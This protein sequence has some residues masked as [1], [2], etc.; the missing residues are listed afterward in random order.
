MKMK[1]AQGI[2]PGA[3]DGDWRTEFRDRIE[4][5]EKNSV[6][7]VSLISSN[8]GIDKDGFQKESAAGDTISFIADRFDDLYTSEAGLVE[9]IILEKKLGMIESESTVLIAA[10]KEKQYLVIHKGGGLI[11]NESDGK[12]FVLSRQQGDALER[13][14]LRV[15]K[16]EL[17]DSF[18]F[19]LLGDGAC[20][21][22]FDY[23]TGNLS[24]ACGTFF[25]W[26][27]EFD[28]EMVSG[29]LVDNINKYFLKDTNGHD[30][31]IGIMVTDESSAE[32][33]GRPQQSEPAGKPA[34]NREPR[35]YPVVIVLVLAVILVIFAATRQPDVMAPTNTDILNSEYKTPAAS[36]KIH[37]PAVSFST[38]TPASYDAGE[39][40]VGTDIPAGEYFFWT[41]KMLEP[42]RIKVNGDT[43]LSG[44]LYCMTIRLNDWDTLVSDYR[45]TAAENVNSVQ[46]VDGVF[47]SGKYKIGKDIVPGIY[48]VKP[49]SQNIEGRYYSISDEE[50]SNDTEFS[51]ETTVEVP[52]EGYVVFLSFGFNRRSE[53][54]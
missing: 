2:V 45:F 7:A 5:I 46:P 49:T 24:P 44:E 50:I 12:C 16:G 41:G 29:A 9:K 3:S 35:K 34:M 36:D 30:I 47:I 17:G 14:N 18:G 38:D 37:E 31:S 43:C 48:T 27:K 4:T 40:E 10:V 52:E 13:K 25:E 53:E 19:L 1:F 8:E 42:D 26:M 23:G 15:F 22:L 32:T 33:D 39:Y 28:G 54:K 11:V 21:S 20:R 51:G 6:S